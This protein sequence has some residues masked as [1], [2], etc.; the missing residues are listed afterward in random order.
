[1]RLS[2][3][4]MAEELSKLVYAKRQWLQ[5]NAAGKHPR[6]DWEIEIRRRELTVLRQAEDDYRS[7]A[8][9]LQSKE[10]ADG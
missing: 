2:H 1:M 3:L 9:R 10:Q 8:N 6:P 5:S 7:A 4:D